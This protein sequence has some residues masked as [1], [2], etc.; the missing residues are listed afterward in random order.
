MR[1]SQESTSQK[2]SVN[3]AACKC[4]QKG[5]VQRQLDRAVSR[6][7]W[8]ILAKKRKKTPLIDDLDDDFIEDDVIAPVPSRPP[9]KAFPVN[10]LAA[11]LWCCFAALSLAVI[12]NATMLQP[13]NKGSSRFAE[14]PDYVPQ[15][16]G[17]NTIVI[18]YDPDVEDVQRELLQ[19]GVYTG[20][21]DGIYG[22]RTRAAIIAY[23]TSNDLIPDG[24]VSGDLLEHIRYRR[25]VVDA[26]TYTGTTAPPKPEMEPQASD[27]AKLLIRKVEAAL[28]DLGYDPGEIDGTLSAQSEKAIR[29]FQADEKLP[30]TG[31]LSPDVL[32][33]LA[34]TTGYEDLVVR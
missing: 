18:R 25:T 26:A 3:S 23:Q 32:T 33:E 31:K 8:K 14:R 12:V 10:P 17:A 9:R 27:R 30:I 7:D 34:K 6:S 1:W 19:V 15:G 13:E 22:E 5:A 29:K 11:T 24:E 2:G 16:P 28:A 21:V 4:R 20:L